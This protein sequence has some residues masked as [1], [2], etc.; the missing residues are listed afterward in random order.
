MLE[1]K[2]YSKTNI[3]FKSILLIISLF[4]LVISNLSIKAN[5]LNDIEKTSTSKENVVNIY[6]FYRTGCPHC[7]AE[8]EFLDALVKTNT[9]IR[10]S[11]YEKAKNLEMF[12]K[13]AD[14]FNMSADART[15]SPVTFIGGRVFE[16]FSSSIQKQM[17]YYIDKYLNNNFVDVFYYSITNQTL[18]SNYL[19]T[20]EVFFIPLIGRINPNNTSLFIVSLI[21]GLVDGFN[22]CGMWVLLFIISLLI[23]TNDK[24][25][26]WIYGGAFI[27]TSGVFYYTILM[28]WT[29][30]FST[31]QNKRL[32]LIIAGVLA[33][34]AGTYNLYKYIKSR[35]KKEEG[36]DVTSVDTKRKISHRIKDL[37][38]KGNLWIALIGIIG[39]T[40]LV[41]LYELACSAGWPAIFASLL[42]V[43]DLSL[44][45]QLFYSLIYVIMFLI[46]DIIVF[47]I[48]VMSLRIKAISNKLTKYSHLIGGIL[49][50]IFGILMIFFP[51]FLTNPF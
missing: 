11:K 19:D 49:M 24:K 22:P 39:V 28:S 31:I 18:P 41:N 7:E 50:L 43:R 3:Y 15:S 16:G 2:Q 9:N 10:V 42:S 27:L 29:T 32:F 40:L 34:I 51:D 8:E 14:L 5:T 45:G 37:L 30:I 46:D 26:I 6:L 12:N 1:K 25:K 33:L 36:C 38:S 47:T 44:G 35:I 4:L 17:E 48:A 13:G 20:E 23:P 21:L